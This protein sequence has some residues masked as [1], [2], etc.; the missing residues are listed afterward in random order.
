MYWT[1]GTGRSNFND[2]IGTTAG[3]TSTVKLSS[4]ANSEIGIGY[5]FGLHRTELNYTGTNGYGVLGEPGIEVKA[6]SIVGTV[7]WDIPW[8]CDICERIYPGLGIGIGATHL[9]LKGTTSFDSY[10]SSY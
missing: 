6:S 9:D 5:D 2:F 1:A 10:G 4:G 3:A 7:V 8:K